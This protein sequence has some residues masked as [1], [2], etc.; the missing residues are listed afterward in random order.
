MY[1]AVENARPR[2]PEELAR[3]AAR[4]AAEEKRLARRAMAAEAGK[5]KEPGPKTT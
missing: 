2:T 5:V 1:E 4:E 3:E